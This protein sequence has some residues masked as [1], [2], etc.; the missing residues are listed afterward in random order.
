MSQI[1][2]KD[3]TG[4]TVTIAAVPNTGTQSVSECLPVT[5]VLAQRSIYATAI[6]S[7]TA[8]G[9][10][11]IAAG[12][13]SLSIAVTGGSV[14]L[15]DGSANVTVVSAVKSAVVL[16]GTAAAPVEWRVAAPDGAALGAVSLGL[17]VG[18]SLIVTEVR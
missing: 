11:T 18:S 10:A 1:S 15:P 9:N 4:A 2:V 14:T 12:A 16:T 6:G 7:V 8:P 17:A 5:P 13:A 3:A